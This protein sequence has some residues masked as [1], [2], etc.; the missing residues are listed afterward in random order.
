MLIAF[1][2]GRVIFGLYWLQ[3]AYNHF[4]NVG[5]LSGYAASKGVPMAKAGVIVSGVLA[6]IGGLG[7]IAG[8]YVNLALSCLIV[9]L[10][11]VTLMIHNF[12]K[13]TDPNQKMSN[14]INFFKNM[15]LLAALLMLFMI[16]QPWVSILHPF[17]Y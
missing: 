14:Q 9:F 1:F 16:A 13:D 8:L 7:I 2:I 15:A 5:M 3:A 12:W 17:N 6:L 4:K 11:P 10:I